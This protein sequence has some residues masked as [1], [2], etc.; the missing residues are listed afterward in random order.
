MEQLFGG[1]I[2]EEKSLNYIPII[3]LLMVS[4]IIIFIVLGYLSYK[5]EPVFEQLVSVTNSDLISQ[6]D[7]T[8]LKQTNSTNS[9]SLKQPK[10]NIAICTPLKEQVTSSSKII[11]QAL[12]REFKNDLLP[13]S[14]NISELTINFKDAIFNNGGF[15]IA[16]QYKTILMEFCPR[17]ISI[18]YKHAPV[19]EAISIEGHSSS[20]WHSSSSTDDAYMSNMLLSQQ[21][22]NAILAYC[23]HLPAM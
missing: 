13:W 12:V 18:L 5:Q 3:G 22:T 20:E 17:Y 6:S 15:G 2:T 10:L 11:Y 9:I 1:N 8:T 19:I 23:L 16:Q 4:V 14:A 7:S 21:R